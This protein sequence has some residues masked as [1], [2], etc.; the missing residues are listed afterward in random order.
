MNRNGCK[1]T[2]VTFLALFLD[3]K[4]VSAWE[5]GQIISIR[6]NA[7]AQ[8]N[9]VISKVHKTGPKT[10]GYDI[11]WSENGI[12]KGMNSIKPELADRPRL[13]LL[14]TGSGSKLYGMKVGD[15]KYI[16]TG[17]GKLIQSQVSKLTEDFQKRIPVILPSRP[18]FET[19]DLTSMKA[20]RGVAPLPPS[21]VTRT[22]NL[23]K[24]PILIDPIKL[25]SIRNTLMG[26]KSRLGLIDT[27]DIQAKKD[28]KLSPEEE[29]FSD[30]LWK[31]LSERVKT[32]ENYPFFT[33]SYPL[34]EE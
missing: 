20:K 24:V 26:I 15:D 12:T 34:F 2:W 18:D 33:E 6:T 21:T 7:G 31:S 13:Y 11:V 3:I 17:K 28:G 4:G 10:T 19:I 27:A 16:F 9:A 25:T 30:F 1:L 23:S 5:A 8:I 32:I 22:T 29:K 14:H